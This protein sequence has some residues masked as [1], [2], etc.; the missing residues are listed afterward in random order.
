MYNYTTLFKTLHLMVWL[1]I[2]R[3]KQ[4]RIIS[5]DVQLERI[6]QDSMEQQSI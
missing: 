6:N 3:C 1:F 5:N 4:K 2:I